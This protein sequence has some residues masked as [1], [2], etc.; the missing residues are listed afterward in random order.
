MT[1][2]ARGEGGGQDMFDLGQGQPGQEQLF[3]YHHMHSSSFSSPA[4]EWEH[5]DHLEDS[6]RRAEHSQTHTPPPPA[7]TTDPSLRPPVSVPVPVPLPHSTHSSSTTATTTPLTGAAASWDATATASEL[8]STSLS[9]ATA[10][11]TATAL[12]MSTSLSNATSLLPRDIT[13]SAYFGLDDMD[14][15]DEVEPPLQ[16]QGGGGVPAGSGSGPGSERR[17]SMHDQMQEAL[18]NMLQSLQPSLQMPTISPSSASS[19]PQA[20]APSA[21]SSWS[22]PRGEREL[23]FQALALA[24]HQVELLFVL[25]TLLSG[26]RKMDVQNR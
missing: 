14:S 25:C 15:D 9:S 13:D 19:G 6:W 1:E 24:P 18:V 2:L 22:P 16:Q 23:R 3:M 11:A 26:R 21:S 5:F 7:A 17:Q 20:T 4:A 12:S 10:T 8:L